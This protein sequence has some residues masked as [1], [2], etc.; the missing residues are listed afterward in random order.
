MTLSKTEK[1][2][3][4][5]KERVS[6]QKQSPSKDWPWLEAVELGN[7]QEARASGTEETRGK[8]RS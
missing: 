6:R 1:A 3:V 5:S 7:S 4:T 2:T 8:K